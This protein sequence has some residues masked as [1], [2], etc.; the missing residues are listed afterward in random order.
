MLADDLASYLAEIAVCGAL[1][2]VDRSWLIFMHQAG[3]A[4]EDILMRGG[5]FLN[6]S[7]RYS[8]G[9]RG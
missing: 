8:L 6:F 4:G 2:T 7:R 5:M 3:E 9:D 1:H